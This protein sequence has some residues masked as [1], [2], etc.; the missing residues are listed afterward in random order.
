MAPEFSFAFL[1]PLYPVLTWSIDLFSLLVLVMIG[2]A[3]F[4]RIVQGPD[5]QR[6]DA[7]GG[8]VILT[9]H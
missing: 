8:R 9:A 4:R 3:Y 6:R 5:F 1:G 2:Y 7:V